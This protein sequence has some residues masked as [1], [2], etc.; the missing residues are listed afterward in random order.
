M[1]LGG[2]LQPRGSR[3]AVAEL[4]A[5]VENRAAGTELEEV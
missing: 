5:M 4:E 1:P 2:S 3:L